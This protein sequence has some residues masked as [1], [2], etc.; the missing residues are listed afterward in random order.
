MHLNMT[1][2]QDAWGV[3]DLAENHFKVPQV[4]QEHLSSHLVPK[5]DASDSHPNSI[6]ETRPT[7]MDVAVY[8]PKVIEYLFPKSPETRTRMVTDLIRASLLPKKLPEP[9]KQT[10]KEY[11]EATEEQATEDNM[12]M[13]MLLTFVLILLD[14]LFHIWKNS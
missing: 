13:L 5:Q 14:K 4:Q 12:T 8:C 2:I 11:F 6:V 7:R 9:K 3:S 1:S 10:T